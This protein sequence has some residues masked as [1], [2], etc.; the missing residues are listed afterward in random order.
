MNTDLLF[1]LLTLTC[2]GF[3]YHAAFNAISCF[4]RDWICE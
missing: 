2:L 4:A 3:V 1:T